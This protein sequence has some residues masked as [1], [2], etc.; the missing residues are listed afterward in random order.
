MQ[1]MAIN[2]RAFITRILALAG[3]YCLPRMVA[4][5]QVQADEILSEPV[6]AAARREASGAYSAAIFTPKRDLRRVMLPSRGHDLAVRPGAQEVVIFARRPGRFAISFSPSQAE[7]VQVFY[8]PHDRHFYGHGVFSADGQLLY[9]SEN[10]FENGRGSIGIFHRKAGYQRIGAFPS[11][12]IGPHDLALLSDK[13]TLVV[14]NGGLETHPASGRQILNLA[15]MKPSLCYIDVV[16][17]DL[18]E[19]VELPA[20]LHQLSIRHLAVGASDR[21]VFGCQFKGA[22]SERPPLMA[23]HDR[24]AEIT[25]MNG[26]D[27]LLNRLDN[28]IGSVTVDK[29]GEFVAAS[30]PRGNLITYWRVAD[31]D[32][33]GERVLEDGC[34]V[35]DTE[36][37]H[38]FL[39]TSGR[40]AIREDQIGPQGL[41]RDLKKGDG[42]RSAAFDNHAV[43]LGRWPA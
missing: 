35:A 42:A 30:A 21:V 10:D 9:T 13:R 38:Q 43:Y 18:L 17:G 24:G 11:Y 22:K 19:K 7:P 37:P 36:T 5:G 20:A 16:T 34:G 23:F 3:G 31:G 1:P 32:F 25:V 28:Y 29:A 41:R 4:D 39:L 40:G 8:P 2:R 26:P 15:E 6:F 33:L 14:A 12:G 27:H